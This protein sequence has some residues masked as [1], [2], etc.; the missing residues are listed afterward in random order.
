MKQIEKVNAIAKPIITKSWLQSHNFYYSKIFS[1]DETDA[2]SYRFP[3]YKYMSRYTL[4]CEFTIILNENVLMINVYD[5]GT[6][7]KY[8]PFYYYEYGNYDTIMKEIY[9]NIE[10]QLKQFN[11]TLESDIK[12]N[13]DNNIIKKKGRNKNGGYSK[14]YN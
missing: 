14:K 12:N 6:R 13:E 3:V 1:D 11:I 9:K 5:Y 2:Y 8:A 7:D 4:E 10:K